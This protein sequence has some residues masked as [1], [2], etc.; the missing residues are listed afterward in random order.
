MNGLYAIGSDASYLYAGVTL[1]NS[2]TRTSEGG[3]LTI[4][5]GSPPTV[6]A[7]STSTVWFFGGG[8]PNDIVSAGAYLYFQSS[9]YLYQVS[10]GSGAVVQ[11]INSQFSQFVAGAGSSASVA[12]V[13]GLSSDGTSLWLVDGG[14]Y[15]YRLAR[16][17]SGPGFGADDLR[18]GGSASHL[19]IDC[20]AQKVQA[21]G[22][23]QDQIGGMFHTYNDLSIP[24]R[25]LPLEFA[26]TYNSDPGAL[27]TGGLFGPGWSFSYGISLAV[28]GSTAVITEENGTKVSFS[29][30]GGNWVPTLSATLATLTQ[31]L[32]GTWTFTRRATDSY[33]FSSSG[34]LISERDLNGDLTTV[35]YPPSE[36]VVTDPAGRTLTASISSGVITALTDSA[37]RTV[38]YGYNDG[39]G[40]LTDVIDTDGGHWQFAYNSS[41]QMVLA[42][43]AR[44][45]STGSLQR[46]RP[47]V[48]RPHR[49]TSAPTC[50]RPGAQ[51][52]CCANGTLTDAR[53]PSTTHRSPG[54][55]KSLTRRA[56]SRSTT[57]RPVCS[58]QRRKDTGHP[59]R[60]HGRRRTTRRP[61]A[62]Q[63]W[64]T[65]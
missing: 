28:S 63:R 32:D 12:S 1:Y 24:G 65:R 57:R 14:G 58:L 61:V 42:R 59:R 50:T 9:R 18:G 44:Y 38:S 21:W 29:Q 46:L 25:G 43:S 34:Q 36:I 3:I 62:S 5:P 16:L 40:N 33:T 2:S 23:V 19:C 17:T 6:N 37:N 53:P 30:S 26:R 22:P 48:Q 13:T 55:P 60:R 52:A 35:S 64:S 27:S 8:Y 41:H 10:K 31:N 54:P 49:L 47:T 4:T 20:L 15:D 51:G 56:T 45:Y 39:N 11:V 7:L